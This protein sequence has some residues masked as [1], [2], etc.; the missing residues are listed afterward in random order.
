MASATDGYAEMVFMNPTAPSRDDL[1]D[2]PEHATPQPAPPSLTTTTPEIPI[3]T[4]DTPYN[5]RQQR[6]ACILCV[7]LI[8][9]L[10]IL[11]P[12][13]YRVLSVD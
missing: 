7:V 9:L 6:Q 2:T 13:F 12:T 3:T 8:V 11:I 5:G 4:I 10:V 1:V